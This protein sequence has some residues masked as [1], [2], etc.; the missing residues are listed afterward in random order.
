MRARDIKPGFY[1]NDELAECSLMA[2]FIFPGLWMMADRRGRFLDRP[3]RIKAE[4]L[5]YDDADVNSLLDELQEHGLIVRYEVDGIRYGYIPKFLSHQKPHPNEKESEFPPC[6]QEI[7]SMGK[8]EHPQGGNPARPK[9]VKA[10]TKEESTSNQGVKDVSPRCEA[11]TTKEKLNPASYPLILSSSSLTTP[12]G[13]KDNIS[14]PVES[15]ENEDHACSPGRSDGMGEERNSPP[16]LL[17]DPGMEFVELRDFYTR[18]VRPEGPLDGFAE[19]KQLKAARD[20][21]GSS[22]WPGLSRIFD[23]LN[24]RKS[25][26]FWNPGYEIGLARYLKTRL[27]QAPISARASPKTSAPTEYQRRQQES[28]ELAK[29]LLEFRQQEQ[30]GLAQ[31]QEIQHARITP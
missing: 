22:H 16:A 11:S 21:T 5:P 1:K 30:A 26:G 23:D 19:Y 25:A 13:V 24:A 9:G 27:W 7:E 10:A 31:T 17:D 4:L 15:L 14:P 3:K 20:K 18:E 28:R 12:N 29:R 2:R 6:P 8:S